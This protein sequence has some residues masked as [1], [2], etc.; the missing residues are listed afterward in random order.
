MRFSN[1]LVATL[2]APMIPACGGTSP[3]ISASPSAPTLA[4][5][6]PLHPVNDPDLEH[7]P[8]KPL[9]SIDWT[10]VALSNDA[11]AL[12]LWRAIAPTGHDWEDKLDEIPV[13]SSTPLAIALLHEGNFACT[14]PQPPTDCELAQE[15][16]P[17]PVATAGLDDPCLRRILALWSIAQLEANDIPHVLDALRSIAT[18]RAP[19]SQLVAAAIDAVPE[20]DHAR[21][22]ELLSIAWAAGQRDLV[23]SK[24]G[25][26]EEPFLIEA[27]RKH[28]IDGALEVLSA[29]AHRPVFLAAIRDDALGA[30]ARVHAIDELVEASAAAKL[31]D[32]VRGAFVGAT[33]SNDCRVAAHAARALEIKGDKRYVPRRPKTRSTAVMM[34]ALCVLA[35]YEQL[36]GSDEDSLLPTFV[37]TKGLEQ[38]KVAFDPLGDVDQDGD[39]DP[40]TDREIDLIERDA[41]VVP[42]IEDIVQAFGQCKGTTCATHDREIRFSFKTVNGQLWL[43]RIELADRPPCS[44]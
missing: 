44:G 27:V 22:L 5:D 3:S 2:V 32:D 12:E 1:L 29:D 28:H 11:E 13:A 4:A 39:G 38:V 20:T 21:K 14:P 19:E 16:V 31:A 34:R 40:R 6:S 8:R 10:K 35:S 23:N 33:K 30:R 24:L 43:S 15:D 17:D 18:L 25:T 37:P 9:L 42:E 7:P 26:L 36:Q 41:V